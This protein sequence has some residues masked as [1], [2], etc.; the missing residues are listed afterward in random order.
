VDRLIIS[1]STSAPA[2]LLVLPVTPFYGGRILGSTYLPVAG[3]VGLPFAQWCGTMEYMIYVVSNTQVRGQLVVCWE[4]RVNP[5]LTF[6]TN[7]VHR[8]NNVLIELSGSSATML[9]VDMSTRTPA[10]FQNVMARGAITTATTANSNGQLMFYL[11]GAVTTV[12][13]TAFDVTVIVMARGGDNMRFGAPTS[14]CTFDGLV[15]VPLVN[16]K[17][18]GTDGTMDDTV[19]VNTIPLVVSPNAN[20]PVKEVLWGEEF[21]SVRALMQKFSQVALGNAATWADRRLVFPHFP[22]RPGAMANWWNTLDVAHTDMPF[23]YGGYYS[24]MF[25][26][27][28][29]SM[30]FKVI[31]ADQNSYTSGGR[32]W[33]GIASA[34]GT[35]TTYLLATTNFLVNAAGLSYFCR[36]DYQ[37]SDLIHGAEFTF[38]NYMHIKFWDP[39]ALLNTLIISAPHFRVD[40]MFSDGNPAATTPGGGDFRVWQAYSSDLCLVRFRRTPGVQIA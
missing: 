17:T 40:A 3:F 16:I 28:R 25:V 36:G 4:P 19:P 32:C 9:T 29:S 24:Q 2:N 5:A 39:R 7:P 37:N 11:Q 31:T 34:S 18:E 27:V 22:N 35:E 1:N 15:H 23:T 10:L 13:T 20:F 33:H 8:V 14:L 6:A 38:P 26:G 21:L 12:K 30:R